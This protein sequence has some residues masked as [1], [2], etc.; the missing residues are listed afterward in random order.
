[1]RNCSVS[2]VKSTRYVCPFS[3]FQCS[4]NFNSAKSL[5]NKCMLFIKGPHGYWLNEISCLI[6]SKVW[7]HYYPKH[8]RTVMRMSYSNNKALTNKATTYDQILCNITLLSKKYMVLMMLQTVI[9]LARVAQEQTFQWSKYQG[10]FFWPV[11]KSI[12]S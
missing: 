12:L 9:F 3:V 5:F 2:M 4:P 6:G 10:I 8:S 7:D 1:M 11:Y